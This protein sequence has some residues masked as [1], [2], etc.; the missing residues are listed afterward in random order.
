MV[1]SSTAIVD[2]NINKL[3]KYIMSQ[4]IMTVTLNC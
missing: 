2:I 4:I 3:T 1:P